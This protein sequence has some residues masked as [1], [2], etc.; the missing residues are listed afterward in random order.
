MFGAGAEAPRCER[1]VRTAEA[2]LAPAPISPAG[3]GW[4]CRRCRR[5]SVASRYPGVGLAAGTRPANADAQAADGGICSGACADAA[6]ECGCGRASP[7]SG[8]RGPAP[9]PGSPRPDP[10]ESARLVPRHGPDPVSRCGGVAV[11][12]GLRRGRAIVASRSR[13]GLLVIAATSGPGG[14]HSSGVTRIGET[15]TV[16]SG[17]GW[18]QTESFR[19][20][21]PIRVG[22]PAGLRT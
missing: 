20:G 8:A 21:I 11:G 5:G 1:G 19:S 14:P 18:L 22:A 9:C 16:Q 3:S 10:S 15:R 2:G 4:S 13:P 6:A 12:G 17:A 7:R